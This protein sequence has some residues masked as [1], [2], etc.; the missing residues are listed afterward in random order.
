MS[1]DEFRI[2]LSAV[3]GEFGVGGQHHEA[4][5]HVI[6]SGEVG[7]LLLAGRNSIWQTRV[8]QLSR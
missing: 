2:F 1:Q 4:D 5:F 8:G 3:T 7:T 6:P